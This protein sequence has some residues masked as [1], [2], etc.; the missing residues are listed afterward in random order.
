MHIK[1]F[2][3]YERLNYKTQLY[4]KGRKVDSILKQLSSNN[5]LVERDEDGIER[6]GFTENG[7][8]K[9][10]YGPKIQLQREINQV[11]DEQ[12]SLHLKTLLD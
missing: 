2:I 1:N 11:E 10:M 12:N 5:A 6:M 4:N 3:K 8:K 9:L 7:K